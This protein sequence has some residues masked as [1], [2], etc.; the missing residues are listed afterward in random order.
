MRS[1]EL[2]GRFSL[3]REYIAESIESLVFFTILQA[4]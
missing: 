4:C 3:S 1:D 2:S